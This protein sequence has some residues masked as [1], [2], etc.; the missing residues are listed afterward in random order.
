MLSA[1]IAAPGKPKSKLE[2]VVDADEPLIATCY[3]AGRACQWPTDCCPGLICE[4]DLAN[5]EWQGTAVCKDPE[6][7]GIHG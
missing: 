3:R 2:T 1:A 5:R 6:R 4:W 7:V